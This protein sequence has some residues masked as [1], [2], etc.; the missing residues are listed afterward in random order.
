MSSSSLLSVFSRAGSRLKSSQSTEVLECSTED[1]ERSRYF[2]S[3][4]K[5]NKHKN[6]GTKSTDAEVTIGCVPSSSKHRLDHLP[7]H[8]PGSSSIGARIAQSDYADP[9]VLFSESR[10]N[11]N[12]LTCRTKLQKDTSDEVT[13]A[14]DTLESDSF[15]EKSFESI[16]D[17]A[18]SQEG[19]F[20][21]SAIFSDVDDSSLKSNE[22]SMKVPPPVPTKK[23]IRRNV[24]VGDKPA[25]TQKP[26]HLK[27]RAKIVRCRETVP[28]K[29]PVTEIRENLENSVSAK[30][31]DVSS[32]QSQVGWVKKMVGQLQAHVDA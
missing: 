22:T 20:R 5:R 4:G 6:N 8:K 26:A 14:A 30:E 21:D 28:E 16:E 24:I 23:K 18:D 2:R 25:L 19:T 7:Y 13:E 15:Y 27:L 31:D 29:M 11:L 1:M 9:L 32:G 10:K 12:N 17:Y 3:F